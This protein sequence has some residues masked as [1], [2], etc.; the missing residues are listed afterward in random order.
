MAPVGQVT[1]QTPQPLHMAS[2]IVA[3][4]GGKVAKHG[5]Y[6]VSSAC[7]SS[8][9]MEYFGYTFSND[10][11]KLK[12]EI[13]KTG[14]C[15]LHAQLFHP[16]MKHVG[17]VRKDMGVKTFFNM[18]GPMINP[19]SLKRQMVGV[20]SLE[21][22]RLYNYVYQTTDKQ[23]AILY[24]LDGYDE[25]SLTGNCKIISA[26]FDKLLSPEELGLEIIR[27]EDISGGTAVKD[28]AKIFMAVLEGKGTKPQK[29]VALANAAVALQCYY[30]EKT[31]KE[32]YAMAEESLESKKALHSFTQLIEMN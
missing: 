30:P 8:N 31:L 28:A 23:Y 24:S 3:G 9:I 15:Y 12:K 14:I 27:A 32:C 19:V 21:L 4:A 25:V 1:A 18:L 26:H 13:D 7:G 6:G 22:T 17:P 2:F 11:S 29:T 20:Y 16:A 5:N 10:E